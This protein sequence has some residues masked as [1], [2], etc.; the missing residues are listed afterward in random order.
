MLTTKIDF[1]PYGPYEIIELLEQGIVTTKEVEDSGIAHTFFTSILS[2][3]LFHTR[4]KRLDD[5]VAC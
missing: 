4:M 5:T 2:D 3:Y 1:S